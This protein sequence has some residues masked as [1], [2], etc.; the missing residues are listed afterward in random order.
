MSLLGI[1]PTIYINFIQGKDLKYEVSD[2]MT[3]LLLERG[4]MVEEMMV[5]LDGTGAFSVPSW[6]WRS[7]DMTD[8]L[9]YRKHLR[10]QRSAITKHTCA[11]IPIYLSQLI[12]PQVVV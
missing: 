12:G 10:E 4:R 6:V 2:G 7:L 11:H 9:A 3:F 5:L 8:R 1:R